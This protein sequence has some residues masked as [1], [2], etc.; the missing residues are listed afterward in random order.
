MIINDVFVDTVIHS[1]TDRESVINA[2]HTALARRGERR[3]RVT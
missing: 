2:A 3:R 1:I